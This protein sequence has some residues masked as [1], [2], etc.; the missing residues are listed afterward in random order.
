M[1]RCNIFDDLAVINKINLDKLTYMTI[2]SF[3]A[4]YTLVQYTVVP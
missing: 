1:L 2:N 3:F 4:N